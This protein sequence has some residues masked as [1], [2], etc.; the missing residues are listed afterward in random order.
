MPSLGTCL[1]RTHLEDPFTAIFEIG[2]NSPL[3]PLFMRLLV[4]TQIKSRRIIVYL[5]SFLFSFH[6][7][8]P[9]YIN[10]SFLAHF[11][12]EKLIGIIYAGGSLLTLFALSEYP[13]VL[14]K[15]GNYKAIVSLFF[16]EILALLLLATSDGGTFVMVAFILSQVFITLGYFSFDVFLERYTREETT[17]AVRGTLLT[18]SNIAILLGPLVT[19]IILTDNEFWKIYLVSATVLFVVFL[20]SFNLKDFKDPLYDRV[21]FFQKIRRV[22]FAKHPHDGIRHVAIANFLMMFFYSW[23]VIYTPL[24]LYQYVGFSWGE[25]GIILPVMLLP[26][27]LFEFVL[28]KLIDRGGSA[29][30]IIVVGF[31]ITALFTLSLFF[32]N[33]TSLVLW[34]ILLFGTR[35]GMS[36]VEIASETYFFKHIRSKDTNLLSIFRDT[37][38]IAYLLGPLLGSF[39]LAFLGMHYL[40]LLLG[41]FMLAGALNSSRMK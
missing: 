5:A 29:R 33:S 38:P 9:L 14:N 36:F 11:F 13:R 12:S 3:S 40:F 17:G 31:F 20:L 19:G 32:I 22:F 21:P 23:M 2:S 35:V 18:V 1:I 16:L 24:Y 25:I 15:F 41:A 39:F 28:G 10:S 26:F 4:E 7:A 34:A 30:L 8:L 6:L 37:Q 27:I